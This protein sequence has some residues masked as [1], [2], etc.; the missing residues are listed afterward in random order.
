MG[1]LD[2]K[3]FHSEFDRWLPGFGPTTPC[4]IYRGGATKDGYCQQMRNGRRHYAHRWAYADARGIDVDDPAM[5]EVV[6]HRCDK[7]RC[8][9]PEHLQAGT[10]YTNNK[11][12]QAK[13]RYPKGSEIHTSRLDVEKV[14]EIRRLHAEEGV[15]QKDLAGWFGVSQSSINRVVLRR[16]WKRVA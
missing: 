14:R 4:N 1:R 11:D 7:R 12:K 10:T 3:R 8:V 5:P 6:E 13:G 2:M 15:A 16:S 9:N